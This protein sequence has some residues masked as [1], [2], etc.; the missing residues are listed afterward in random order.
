MAASALMGAFAAVVQV[1]VPMAASL[2]PVA[3]RGW[4]VGIVFSGLLVGVL[5][6]RSVGG[7]LGGYIGWR[8]LYK[9]EAVALALMAVLLRVRLPRSRAESRLSYPEL[10]KSVMTLPLESATLREVAFYGACGFGALSGFWS[11]LVFFLA[12]PPYHYGANMAGILALAGVAAALTAPLLGRTADRRGPWFVIGIVLVVGVSSYLPLYWWGDRIAGLLAGIILLD[13]SVNACM[14]S[15]QAAMYAALPSAASRAD[16]FYMVAYF[17]GGAMGTELSS[18]AWNIVGWPG[19][20]A[21]GAALFSAALALYVF[22]RSIPLLS[23]LGA[24]AARRS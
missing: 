3:D 15:N 19:V 10:I 4:A 5:G 2:S 13:F 16:T 24:G 22:K 18:Q 17:T 7:I 23:P 11:T 14:V 21:V 6:A 20:C 12:R 9:G 1:I 8:I